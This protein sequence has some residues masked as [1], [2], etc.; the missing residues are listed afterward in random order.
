MI[1]KILVDHKMSLPQ[2]LQAIEQMKD[3]PKK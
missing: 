2:L 3:L 1:A